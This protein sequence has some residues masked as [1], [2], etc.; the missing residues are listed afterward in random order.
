MFVA[1]DFTSVTYIPTENMV[2]AALPLK[3]LGLEATNNV[4]VHISM[5][6]GSHKYKWIGNV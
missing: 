1:K 2:M 5:S 3:Y 4:F 6:A